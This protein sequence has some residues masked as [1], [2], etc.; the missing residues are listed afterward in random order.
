MVLEATAANTFNFTIPLFNASRRDIDVLVACSSEDHRWRI[1]P[2]VLPPMALASGEKQQLA[3]AA[4]FDA[5]RVPE[6]D[7]VCDLRVP[8]QTGHGQWL[9][10][11]HRVTGKR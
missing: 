6:S 11:E 4:A 3:L 8:F 7:P 9:D 1:T 2:K 10:F 5:D